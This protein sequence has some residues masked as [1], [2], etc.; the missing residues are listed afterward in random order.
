M[1]RYVVGE[2]QTKLVRT[3]KAWKGNNVFCLQGRLI[4]GPD[5]R[6]LPL[7]IFLIVGPLIIFLVMVGRKLMDDFNHWGVAVVVAPVVFTCWTLC[8][9]LLTSSRDPGII[10]RNKRPPEPEGYERS[11]ESLPGQ[12]P[13]LPRTKDVVVNGT[14]VKVKYCDTCMMYRTPRSSHCSICDNCV[15]RFDHH[16]PWVGQC[17]G[18]RN[19]RFF[20]MFVTSATLLCV[21]VFSFCWVYITMI[22][23][24][25]DITIWKAMIKTP[26]SIALIVYTFIAT[27]FVG[28]LSV[29]HFYLISTNQTTYENFRYNYDRR[30]NPFNRG[31]F[32]N[33][34]EVFCTSIPPSKNN[35]RALVPVEVGFPERQVSRDYFTSNMRKEYSD[36][37]MGKNRE[38]LEDSLQEGGH[39]GAQHSEISTEKDAA[40]TDVGRSRSA[41]VPPKQVPYHP[42]NSSW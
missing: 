23:R 39:H 30:A 38:W 25:E 21:Y 14:V 22:K 20:Y 33:F 4:F 35:F 11:A 36:I 9:L 19:Y 42:R 5:V 37:E 40:T 27:W 28:G 10:P 12:T 3:Y 2:D 24:S 18:V 34:A 32:H 16:C 8:V 6:S 29:F 13:R 15:E 17:I 41:K 26:A 7:T 1:E 31:M